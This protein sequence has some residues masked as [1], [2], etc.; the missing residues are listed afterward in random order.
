[1]ETTAQ[2]DLLLRLGCDSLQGYLLSRPLTV[3]QTD[4]LLDMA[5]GSQTTVNTA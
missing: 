5:C 3:E 1:V 2:R 4:V